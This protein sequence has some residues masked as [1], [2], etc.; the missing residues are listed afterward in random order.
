M[1]KTL[2]RYKLVAVAGGGQQVMDAEPKEDAETAK[3]RRTMDTPCVR[4]RN[5]IGREV[6]VIVDGVIHPN[7]HYHK[8]CVAV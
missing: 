5:P 7:G 4:C 1:N 6:F 3:A 2:E 8:R